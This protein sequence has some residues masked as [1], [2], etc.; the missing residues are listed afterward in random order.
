VGGSQQVPDHPLLSSRP[1]CLPSVRAHAYGFGTQQHT[2]QCASYPCVSVPTYIELSGTAVPYGRFHWLFPALL[3]PVVA[4]TDYM[5]QRQPLPSSAGR[6]GVKSVP[7]T[8]NAWNDFFSHNL[9]LRFGV[10]AFAKAW[11]KSTE[12][13]LVLRCC[14]KLNCLKLTTFA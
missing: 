13:W 4:D 3:S 2:I 8:R 12:Q 6:W 14:A 1:S 5:K 7:H 11:S 10:F 9:K